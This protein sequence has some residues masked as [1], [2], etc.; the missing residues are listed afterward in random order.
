[1]LD[2]GRSTQFSGFTE[3]GRSIDSG[4]WDR[5]NIINAIVVYN[6][7]SSQ[8]LEITPISQDGGQFQLSPYVAVTIQ[9]ETF[10]TT[11]NLRLAPQ[12]P[13]DFQGFYHF[14]RFY[15]VDALSSGSE[16]Q[17]TKAYELAVAY[18]ENSLDEGI[19]ESDIGLFFW[20]EDSSRWVE[21][22]STVD[23][24]ANTVIA[25]PNHFSQWALLTRIENEQTLIYL[26]MISR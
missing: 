6:I 8:P 20:D 7:A 24:N 25:H 11:V 18:T 16:V 15:T 26:P 12:F 5:R 1:M 19:N 9:P 22:P 21:E 3:S 23:V 10:P 14:N 13:H 2:G 17:P 4:S